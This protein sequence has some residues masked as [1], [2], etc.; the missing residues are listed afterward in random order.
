M[1][2]GIIYN[3]LIKLNGGFKYLHIL[4]IASLFVNILSSSIKANVVGFLG[5]I[6]FSLHRA[7]PS[8]DCVEVMWISSVLSYLRTKFAFAEQIGH[9][10]SKIMIFIR[11]VS[12][13]QVFG[14][15]EVKKP[16]A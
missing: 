2:F 3:I 1:F 4:M 11:L 14:L 16:D 9:M 6:L 12:S 7:C 15:L 13:C 8:S 10:L 5:S